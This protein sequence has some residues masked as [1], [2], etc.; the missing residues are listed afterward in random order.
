[1]KFETW[2]KKQKDRDDIVGD[3][4]RDFIDSNCKTLKE[5]LLKYPPSDKTVTKCIK[6]SFKE[7][8]LFVKSSA[9]RLKN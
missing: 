5:S 7:Y 4:A 3:V 9:L 1:M 6:D 8:E 2:L